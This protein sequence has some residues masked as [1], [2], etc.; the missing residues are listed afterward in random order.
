MAHKPRD[1]PGMAELE[2]VIRAAVARGSPTDNDADR[3]S[4]AWLLDNPPPPP[5][6][7]PP[8]TDSTL[9]GSDE[10]GSDVWE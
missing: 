8:D 6:P 2:G 10:S 4:V 1:R 5:P 9:V 3:S 7:P